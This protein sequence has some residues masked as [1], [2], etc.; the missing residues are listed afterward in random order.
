MRERKSA[1]L[2]VINPSRKVLLFRFLHKEGALAGMTIGPRPV[3][4]L[5]G[6][7]PSRSPRFVNCTRKPVFRSAWWESRWPVAGSR[8]SCPVASG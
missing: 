7:K 6:T 1:R 5:K 3:A 2:L 8:C 4:G